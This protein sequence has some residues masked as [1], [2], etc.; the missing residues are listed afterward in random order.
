MQRLTAEDKVQRSKDQTL[1]MLHSSGEK[2]AGWPDRYWETRFC[3]PISFH[4]ANRSRYW[5]ETG[6][7]EVTE[8]DNSKL[9]WSSSDRDWNLISKRI[10]GYRRKSLNVDFKRQ[11]CAQGDDFRTFLSDFV[12]SLT[13]VEFPNGL[14]LLHDTEP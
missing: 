2:W 11:W 13:Q 10:E 1:E 9:K 5:P 6:F 3:L 7:W 8:P 4:S 14:T 12:A